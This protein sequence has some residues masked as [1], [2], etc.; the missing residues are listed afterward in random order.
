MV[1]K[2]GLD[3]LV[4]LKS[5]PISVR[6]SVIAISRLGSSLTWVI[7]PSKPRTSWET[8]SVSAKTFLRS[9]PPRNAN[10]QASSHDRFS[11]SGSQWLT[12]NSSNFALKTQSVF[13]LRFPISTIARRSWKNRPN[14]IPALASPRWLDSDTRSCPA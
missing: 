11:S 10:E 5:V 8:V 14:S 2:Y 1:G 6:Y 12:S 9:S 4:T 7:T 13:L 3:K